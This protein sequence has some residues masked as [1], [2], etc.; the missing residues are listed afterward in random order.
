VIKWGDD[1]LHMYNPRTCSVTACSLELWGTVSLIPVEKREKK[2]NKKILSGFFKSCHLIVRQ[3]SISR[4]RYPQ[5]EPLP[6]DHAAGRVGFPDCLVLEKQLMFTFKLKTRCAPKGLKSDPR[7]VFVKLSLI[8]F[9]GKQCFLF[10]TL[11]FD[12]TLTSYGAV[13]LLQKN[14]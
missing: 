3:V 7:E 14:N 4:P 5:V 9:E 1:D 2:R 11:L 13:D 6:L 8:A 12:V 10:R